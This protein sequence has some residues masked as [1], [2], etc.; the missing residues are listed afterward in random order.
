VAERRS[1]TPLT[2]SDDL[3]RLYRRMGISAAAC[4]EHQATHGE[5]PCLEV[6]GAFGLKNEAGVEKDQSYH[7]PMVEAS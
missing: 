7:D 5:R 1:P 6:D 2:A 4:S 3:S